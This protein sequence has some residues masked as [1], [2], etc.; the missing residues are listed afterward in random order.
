[1]RNRKYENGAGE[2]LCD[3]VCEI[4]ARHAH[5]CVVQVAA[6]LA[7]ALPGL[8]EAVVQA[9]Y[10]GQRVPKGTA[11]KRVRRDARIRS[12]HAAG[13]D[14]NELSRRHHLSPKTIASIVK[15]SSPNEPTR[16]PD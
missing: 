11:E 10:A 4:A 1:M 6:G 8:I 3:I 2:R 12:E 9:R 14:L 15:R 7:Q 16:E 5:D 13:S